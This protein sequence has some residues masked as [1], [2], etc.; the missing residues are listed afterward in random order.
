MKILITGGNGFIAKSLNEAF[1]NK[2]DVT[3]LSRQELNLFDSE[4]VFEVIQKNKFDVI[5]HCATYD[6]APE[7]STKDPSKVLENNLRMFFNIARCK[8]YFGKLIYFGSGAEFNRDSWIPKMKE[9]YFN[10][11]IP[12]DQYGYSKFLMTKYTALKSNIYNL[13]LFG[14]FG[15]Y[16]DWR[17]RF[18][19]NIC[20]SAVLDQPITINQN[21]AFDYLYIDD[22]VKIVDWFINN[23]PRYSV[24]N[25]CSGEPYELKE[26]AKKVIDITG[27]NTEIEIKN[28]GMG[29]EYSG[30]NSRLMAE[31][32]GF[33]YT[34]IEQSIKAMLDWYSNNKEIFKQS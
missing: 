23:H 26:L 11:N 8:D 27:K 34:P 15:K 32:Q 22:L 1:K 17:Y 4:K 24:Y 12:T 18:I 2:Y 31:L 20:M 7:F 25:V 33:Q 10:K 5:I 13:R 14:V 28:E 29:N 3:I 9:E 6:A 21:K 16:D 19:P 30:D